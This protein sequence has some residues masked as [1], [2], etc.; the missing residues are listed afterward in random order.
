MAAKR[1]F[2]ENYFNDDVVAVARRLIGAQ[3]LVNHVGGTIIETEAYAPDDPA[4]HS[5]RGPTP[6]S[7]PMFGAPGTV[8]VYRSYGVHW[9]VNFVC[10]PGNAVLIRA[11]FPTDGIEHMIERRAVPD[12]RKLCAGPGRLTQA[13]GI[14]L[15]H[16]ERP[17]SD[18]PFDFAP[19]PVESGV[20]AGPRIGIT[21]ATDLAW[22]FGLPDSKY[23]SR[24]FT[25][26]GPSA[27]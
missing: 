14:D 5:F 19:A 26:N 20:I 23:L 1:E 25:K 12:R 8:Y 6:R 3:F 4:S 2:I 24:P 13:L 9:C 7:R 15:E 17:L 16:N 11:L 27:V 22:R 10:R 18:L 21:K